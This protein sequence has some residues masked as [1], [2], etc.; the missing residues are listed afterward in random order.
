ME[1][2]LKRARSLLASVYSFVIRFGDPVKLTPEK[3]REKNDN[4][5]DFCF[6]YAVCLYFMPRSSHEFACTQV[7]AYA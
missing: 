6:Q 7:P 4:T 1:W 3:L 2:Y 5:T